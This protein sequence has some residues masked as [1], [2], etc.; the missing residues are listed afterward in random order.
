MALIVAAHES[1][2]AT[3]APQQTKRYINQSINQSIE[4]R[5]AWRGL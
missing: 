2:V 1:R 3:T 5:P 4:Y